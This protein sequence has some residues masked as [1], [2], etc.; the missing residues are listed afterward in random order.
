MTNFSLSV[1]FFWISF[2]AIYDHKPKTHH[3][4]IHDDSKDSKMM[5]SRLCPQPNF[6][7][8]VCYARGHSGVK[9]KATSLINK[10][11]RGFEISKSL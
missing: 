5:N 10:L 11:Q 3:I 6:S 8:S 9:I 1:F 7:L 4:A 2:C